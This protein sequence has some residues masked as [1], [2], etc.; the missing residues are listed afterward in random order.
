MVKNWIFIISIIC[1]GCA[2]NKIPQ[3]LIPRETFKSILIDIKSAK[4][5]NKAKQKIGTD[6]LF[7]LN[8]ALFKHGV[9]DTIYHKTV[10]FYAKRPEE[11]LAIIKEIETLSA[12]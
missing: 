12:E 9:S 1:F 5:N 8:Q 4:S 2:Q 6:S 3:D 10:L 7:F 11:L